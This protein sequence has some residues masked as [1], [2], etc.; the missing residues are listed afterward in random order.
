MA[1]PDRSLLRGHPAT[2]SSSRMV[3]YPIQ[4]LI[5]LLP[6]TVMNNTP[7]TLLAFSILTCNPAFADEGIRKVEKQVLEDILQ[8]TTVT[9]KAIDNP[10]VAKCF[11][12]TFYATKI[13]TQEG[14]SWT[15]RE[16]TYAMTSKGIKHVL[17]PGSPS[18]MKD[19]HGFLLPSFRLKTDEDGETILAA[20]HALYGDRFIDRNFDMRFKQK[21]STWSFITGKFFKKFSGVVIRTDSTGAVTSIKRSLSIVE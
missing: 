9:V 18:E 17:F 3:D 7:A 2:I 12:G 11:S 15:T 19:L 8:N 10:S 5:T 13:R 20:L 14:D 1:N 16:T 6:K 21:G 4:N